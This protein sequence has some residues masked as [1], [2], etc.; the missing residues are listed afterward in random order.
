MCFEGDRYF[1][2]IRRMMMGD[3]D[4][5]NIY[6]MNVTADDGGQ[7]FGF[8]DFYQRKLFQTRYWNDRMYLFPI[9][10]SDI[11]KDNAIV[12]NPGW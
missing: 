12:Q 3:A 1:T 5:K 8:A 9:D 2:L 11:D 4:V 6:R 7:G 10:Q